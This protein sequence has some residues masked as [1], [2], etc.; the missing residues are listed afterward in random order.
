MKRVFFQFLFLFLIGFCWSAA[1]AAAE[2]P[3]VGFLVGAGGLGDESYNDMTLAGLVRARRVYGFRLFH[4]LCDE[5]PGGIHS[6]LERL[7]EKGVGVIVLN[8]I[9]HAKIVYRHAAENPGIYF[10][11]NDMPW[12]RSPNMVC[13]G[14]AHHE[15][16]FLVGALAGWMTRSGAVGFIGGNDLPVIRSFRIGFQEGVRYAD[17]KVRVLEELVARGNDTSGFNNPRKGYDLAGKL[18]DE[19]ADILFAAAG[20]S[21]N[22][23]IHAARTHG[24]Y[25]IGVDTD[26]DHMAKGHVLTSMIKRLDEATA[27]E[28]SAI[29]EG[30][31]TPGVRYYGLREGGI[32]LSPMKYTRHLIPEDVLAR[33]EKARQ[34][35]IDGSVQVTTFDYLKAQTGGTNP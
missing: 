18:Y 10:I 5:T 15:G 9:A 19:G 3:S 31:F 7:L 6:A 8:R 27:S 20:L 24:L 12:D 34:G 29:M 16:A 30:R 35:I 28:V 25:V 21:G 17:P 2:Y 22:G 11:V 4:E 1:P 23:V 14:Y 26:Q 13:L 33:L 32:G